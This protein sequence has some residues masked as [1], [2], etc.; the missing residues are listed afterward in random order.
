MSRKERPIPVSLNKYIKNMEYNVRQLWVTDWIANFNQTSPT[1]QTLVRSKEHMM[2]TTWTIKFDVSGN[3]H[4]SSTCITSPC[5]CEFHG[6]TNQ[7]HDDFE[8]AGTLAKTREAGSFA[9]TLTH[10]ARISVQP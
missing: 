5:H 6:V 1:S 8:Q 3:S 10:A 4:K 7:I 9:L 2:L